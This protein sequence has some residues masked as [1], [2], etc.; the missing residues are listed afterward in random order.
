MIAKPAII[1]YDAG[2]WS[3]LTQELAHN[4][5]KESFRKGRGKNRTKSATDLP[6][7]HVQDFLKCLTGLGEGVTM[8]QIDSASVNKSDLNLAEGQEGNKGSLPSD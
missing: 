3:D 5:G 8:I 6:S 2:N 1:G 7:S 4:Q